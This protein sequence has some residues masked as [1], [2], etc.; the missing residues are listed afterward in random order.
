MPNEPVRSSEPTW[1]LPALLLSFFAFACASIAAVGLVFEGFE[2]LTRIG[3][4]AG[5]PTSAALALVIWL[6]GRA[7]NKASAEDADQAARSASPSPIET[8]AGP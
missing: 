4:V 2:H 3:V 8:I 6:W 1:L 5:I 7:C